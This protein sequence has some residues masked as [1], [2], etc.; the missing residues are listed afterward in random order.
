M[1]SDQEKLR[2]IRRMLTGVLAVQLVIAAFLFLQCCCL[3]RG[4]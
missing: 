1:I 4:K 2:P 3:I